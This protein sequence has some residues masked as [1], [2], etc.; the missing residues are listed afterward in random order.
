[1]KKYH[2]NEED[3]LKARGYIAK[4][5]F[6]LR[7]TKEALY[8]NKYYHTILEDVEEFYNERMLNWKTNK[9]K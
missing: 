9:E 5:I 7:D 3:Y 4:Y 8:L 6:L 2:I 1:M